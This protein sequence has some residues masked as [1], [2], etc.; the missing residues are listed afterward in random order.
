MLD[1]LRP[2]VRRISGCGH[3]RIRL[4]A[5]DL[6]ALELA[7]RLEPGCHLVFGGCSFRVVAERDAGPG[8]REFDLAWSESPRRE[9]WTLRA[10][11]DGWTLSGPGPAASGY[12]LPA[13]EPLIFPPANEG[14]RF[15]RR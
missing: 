4:G 8:I 14:A 15:R 6:S 13:S 9:R 10:R 1:F 12:R 7:D 3:P 11:A 5:S 2:L